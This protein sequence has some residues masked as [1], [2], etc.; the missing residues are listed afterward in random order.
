[1]ADKETTQAQAENKVEVPKAE[2]KPVGKLRGILL[3]LFM[4]GLVIMFIFMIMN[5]S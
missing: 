3:I 5:R 4:V 2:E 1:M